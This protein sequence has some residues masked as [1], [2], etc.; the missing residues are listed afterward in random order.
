MSEKQTCAWVVERADAFVDNDLTDTE[1]SAIV[2]HCSGC[3]ACARELD[4]AI[5]TRQL[6]RALPAFEAPSH[7]VDNAESAA[8]S[9]SARVIPLPRRRVAL[10]LAAV[11]AVVALVGAGVWVGAQKRAA[12]EA[13]LEDA[14]VRR[15]RDG[16]AIAFGYVGRYSDGVVRDD[17]MGKRVL[18][19]IERALGTSRDQRE[20]DRKPGDRRS[21]L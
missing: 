12:R 1:R 4:V 18:P 8:L 13:T 19:R 21:G 7:V 16:L 15:A 3:G 6:L 14:E 10:R 11:A 9:A 2:R 5:R 17:V 20:S